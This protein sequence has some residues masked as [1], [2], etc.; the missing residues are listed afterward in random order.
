MGAED[1]A[2][3]GVYAFQAARRPLP[4]AGE[5]EAALREVLARPEF[6][7]GREEPVRSLL[8]RAIRA[9]FRWL[10]AVIPDVPP[11]PGGPLLNAIAVAALAGAA[12]LVARRLALRRR[13]P[14]AR[15]EA[16]ASPETGEASVRRTAEEWEEHAHSLLAA[17]RSREAALALHQ[18][19]LRRL[20]DAGLIRFHVSK[21]PGDYEREVAGAPVARPYVAF[22]AR[23]EPVAFGPVAAREGDVPALF[24]LA[25]EAAPSHG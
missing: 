17:G 22:R 24:A 25:R 4:S 11:L 7:P 3:S 1:L 23:F 16:A 20:A 19:V 6:Q 15:R 13:R 10:D 14:T 21:T 18:A 2:S 12:L 5:V 8:A 9:L